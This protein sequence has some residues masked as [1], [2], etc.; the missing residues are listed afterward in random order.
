VVVEFQNT[1]SK[2]WN[3][4]STSS[5]SSSDKKIESR[6]K[7]ILGSLEFLTSQK[8]N[9]GLRN[10]IGLGVGSGRSSIVSKKNPS[11]SLV[12]ESVLYGR[13]DEK[14]MIFN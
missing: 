5:V 11:T 10:A 14:E 7:Q 2:V 12:V 9:L 8:G 1:A 3:L 6:M 4:S 13:D